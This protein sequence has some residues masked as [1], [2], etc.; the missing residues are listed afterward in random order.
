MNFGKKRALPADFPVQHE[1]NKRFLF[2]KSNKQVVKNT[3]AKLN[4]AKNAARGVSANARGNPH[5][6][7]IDVGVK[8]R[9]PFVRRPIVSKSV[10]PKAKPIVL[11][12]E[13]RAFITSMKALNVQV[14]RKEKLLVQL[15]N[16]NLSPEPQIDE[17]KV[18]EELKHREE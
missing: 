14:E 15:T 1:Q 7:G 17:G 11:S 3:G 8:Q 9:V 5:A 13:D 2:A 4:V 12:Y 18:E 10:K 6:R 16:L